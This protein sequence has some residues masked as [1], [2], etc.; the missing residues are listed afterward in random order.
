MRI[1]KG[2]KVF[3]TKRVQIL[4]IIEPVSERPRSQQQVA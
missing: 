3:A 2:D 1:A 4:E